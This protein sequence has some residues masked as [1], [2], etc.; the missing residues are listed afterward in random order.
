MQRFKHITLKSAACGTEALEAFDAQ[1]DSYDLVF[2]DNIMPNMSGLEV[3]QT[4]RKRKYTNLIIGVTGNSLDIDLKEFVEAGAD[5]D[6]PKPIRYESIVSIVEHLEKFGGNSIKC[7]ELD[8]HGA[9]R[10][11]SLHEIESASL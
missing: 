11:A 10:A 1:P 4:L 2:M 5:I 7:A 3:S 9:R 8:A 6:L